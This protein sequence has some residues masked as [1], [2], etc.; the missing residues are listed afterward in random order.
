[1]Q[2]IDEFFYSRKNAN[3]FSAKVNVPIIKERN[4]PRG[5]YRVSY[6]VQLPTRVKQTFEEFKASVPVVNEKMFILWLENTRLSYYYEKQIPPT[7][8]RE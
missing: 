3:I 8:K 4:N 6:Y 5:L 1:M 7:K 2:R